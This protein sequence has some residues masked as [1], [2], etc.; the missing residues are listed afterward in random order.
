MG[1]RMGGATW[2]S[3]HPLEFE[4]DDVV[5]SLECLL[6]PWALA[7][8]ALKFILKRR[9]NI[10]GKVRLC[11]RRIEKHA[12]FASQCAFAPLEKFAKIFRLLTC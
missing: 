2:G 7:S 3:C 5:K 8:N 11:L 10:R 4:N 9:R 6:V 1:D 12:I